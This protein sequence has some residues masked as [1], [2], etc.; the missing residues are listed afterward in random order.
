MVLIDW[1]DVG[2]CARNTHAVLKPEYVVNRQFAKWIAMLYSRDV[3]STKSSPL[4]EY[5]DPGA[6]RV[7]ICCR[8]SRCERSMS[9]E[10]AGHLHGNALRVE[11]RVDWPAGLMIAD[12]WR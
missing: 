11:A 2:S 3:S 12:S 5:P 10:V 7:D 6:I 8:E 1:S 4:L 9:S